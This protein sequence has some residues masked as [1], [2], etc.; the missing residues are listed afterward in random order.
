M[1][2][3]SL[4]TIIQACS[5]VLGKT[6]TPAGATAAAAVAA[7]AAAAAAPAAVAAMPT[8][9]RSEKKK[10]EIF[11]FLI[12]ENQETAKIVDF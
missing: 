3:S 2:S 5:S 9:W 12:A 11:N 7:A 6:R 1:A 10:L 8:A 4:S